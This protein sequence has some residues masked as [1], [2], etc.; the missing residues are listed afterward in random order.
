MMGVDISTSSYKP[1][2]IT[3]FIAGS[4]HE[5]AV[6]YVANTVGSCHQLTMFRATTRPVHHASQQCCSCVHCRF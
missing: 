1:V 2:L 6:F 3:I 4:L 5:L